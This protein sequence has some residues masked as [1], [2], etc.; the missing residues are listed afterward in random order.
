METLLKNSDLLLARGKAIY[1]FCKKYNNNVF[2]TNYLGWN[3]KKKISYENFFKFNKEKNKITILFIG[4]IIF[5]KGIFDLLKIFQEIVLKYPDIKFYMNIVGDGKDK[6]ILTEEISKI[7]NI[8]YFGWIDNENKLL[9]IY[10]K[11]DLLYV[12]QD[13]VIQRVCQE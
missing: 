13:Q 12:L 5:E 11:S 3:F 9:D 8:H 6:H 7:E 10:N 2:V 4:K 1:N